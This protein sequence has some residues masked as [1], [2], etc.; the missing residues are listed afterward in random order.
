MLELLREIGADVEMAV[1]SSDTRMWSV[2]E[3]MG[4]DGTETSGIDRIAE[5]AVFNALE[6]HGNPLNVLSEEAGFVDFGR[7]LTLV[8]DPLDGTYNAKTGIPFFSVSLAVTKGSLSDVSH[9]LVRNIPT[10]DEYTASKG[11]GAYMN[12][13]RIHTRVFS[14][15][16]SVFSIFLGENASE[17]SREISRKCTRA[18]SMGSAALEIS[19]VASGSSDLYCYCGSSLSLGLRIVDIAGAYLILKEA[20]GEMFD[21][22]LIKLDMPLDVRKRSS[23]IAVGSDEVKKVIG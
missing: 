8:V 9:A 3:G 1:K 17:R 4:A 11:K 18:R 10:G 23:V 6:R 19:L 20:G 2:S 7:E 16:D 15:R 5:E 22:K 12:G 21:G 14:P 13:K